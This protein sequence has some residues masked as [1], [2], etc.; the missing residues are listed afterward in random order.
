MTEEGSKRGENIE[1]IEELD[2][3]EAFFPSDEDSLEDIDVN[4][5]EDR[6]VTSYQTEIEQY[7]ISM[8][9]IDANPNFIYEP[10]CGFNVS[11]AKAFPYAE[12]LFADIKNKKVENV[13]RAGYNVVRADAE[14]LALSENPDITVLKRAAFDVTRAL[15]NNKS[16]YVFANN[17]F[18]KAIEIEEMESH[19]LI[20]KV[21]ESQIE[22]EESETVNKNEDEDYLYIFQSKE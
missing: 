16:D 4:T 18:H 17:R 14:E 12:I 2:D 10:A 19:E 15:E 13:N 20:G 9:K 1:S 21:G 22:W 11:I 6:G 7:K 5:G 8:D 3:L